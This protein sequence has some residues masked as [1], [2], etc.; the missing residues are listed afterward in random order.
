MKLI[1]CM[2]VYDFS[3]HTNCGVC[4]GQIRTLDLVAMATYIMGK[5]KN[6]I[7]FLFSRDILI[8]SFM[9]CLLSSPLCFI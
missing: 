7:F 6:D 1:L 4:S 3:L 8:S 9:K 2:H 5:V